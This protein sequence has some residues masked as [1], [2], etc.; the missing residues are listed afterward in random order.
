LQARCEYR[1]R[2]NR[3][4][5]N[6]E[7]SSKEAGEEGSEKGC[8]EEVSKAR[9]QATH[10]GDAGKASPEVFLEVFYARFAQAPWKGSRMGAWI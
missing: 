9:Q 3:N 1:K 8:E 10:S 2:E 7:S 6:Q 5:G 4:N